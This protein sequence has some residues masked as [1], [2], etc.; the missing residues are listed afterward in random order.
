M[1]YDL[2]SIYEV[3]IAKLRSL[4]NVS[5]IGNEYNVILEFCIPGENVCI[6]RPRG[7]KYEYFHFYVGVLEDFNIHLPFTDFESDLLKT[8]SIAPSQ[9]HYNS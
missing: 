9:L 5:S 3:K 8:L 7:V 6:A 1:S 2:S 4:K